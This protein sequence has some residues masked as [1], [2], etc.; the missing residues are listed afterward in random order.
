VKAGQRIK[1]KWDGA[2]G[3]IVSLDQ[4]RAFLK[5]DKPDEDGVSE[6]FESLEEIEPLEQ[7]PEA[8]DFDKGFGIGGLG[9]FEET[10]YIPTVEQMEREDAR[11]AKL[12]RCRKCGQLEG[13]VMFSTDPDSGLCDDCYG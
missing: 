1:V 7:A 6:Y 13:D 2:T 4:H 10:P 9:R 8:H 3:T 5:M 12:Q 11:V